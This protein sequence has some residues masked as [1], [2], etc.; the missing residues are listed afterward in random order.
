MYALKSTYRW[1]LTGTPLQNRVSE[2]YALIRFLVLAPHSYYFCKTAGCSCISLYWEFGPKS[3]KCEQCGCTPM[4]HYS[5]FNKMVMNP[6]KRYGYIGDGRRAMLRLK[7]DILDVVMLRRTKVE[8]AEDI[9]L[10]PLNINIEYL[11]LDAS[12]R[13]F[14]ECIYKNSRSKFDTYVDKGTLLNN[15]AHVFQLLSRLRQTLDHPYLVVHG[16]FEGKKQNLPSKSTGHSD[17]CGVCGFD[18]LKSR[19]CVLSACHHT[20]HNP[21]WMSTRKSFT[22]MRR[23]TM[24]MQIHCLIQSKRKRKRGGSSSTKSKKKNSRVENVVTCPV[25]FVP[26]TIQM[27]EV[28]GLD[29]TNDSSTM[30]VDDPT[31]CI[32]CMENERNALLVPCGHIYTCKD[33]TDVFRKRKNVPVRYV[34]LPY[35]K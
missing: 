27:G 4:R 25:C 31:K 15:Y 1:C 7:E 22:K 16:N 28:R 2:L 10:P 35:E 3:R 17:V 30:V 14:Y 33:C 9:K 11:T 6:I 5:F 32:I 18:I 34:V 19:E 29:E 26:L 24:Q 12:E 20:F 13:D 8:R 23:K 21:V